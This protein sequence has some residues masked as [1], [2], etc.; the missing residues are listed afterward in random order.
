M[1]IKLKFGQAAGWKLTKMG[2]GDLKQ[3]ICSFNSKWW[4]NFSRIWY[5]EEDASVYQINETQAIVQTLVYITPVVD[6][7]YFGQIAATNA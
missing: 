3:T 1:N 5:S 6:D 7:P 4:K 2:P